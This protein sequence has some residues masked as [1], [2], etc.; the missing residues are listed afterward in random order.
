MYGNPC[1]DSHGDPRPLARL[2][3]VE[4]GTIRLEP[5]RAD[6]TRASLLMHAGFARYQ[7]VVIATYAGI[8][9]RNLEELVAVIEAGWARLEGSGRGDV[10]IA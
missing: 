2:L 1:Q 4:A 7:A 3:D 10:D 8:E 5:Q 6:A 9:P